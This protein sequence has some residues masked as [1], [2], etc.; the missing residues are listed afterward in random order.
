MLYPRFKK[1]NL[2][3]EKDKY[4]ILTHAYME[5][6]KMVPTTRP[7][8]Q[9]RRHRHKEQTLLDSVE[10]G[11]DGM[12]WENSTEAYTLSYVKQ[13]ASGSLMYDAGTQSQC[14]VTTWR[15]GVG[16][17]FGAGCRMERTNVCMRSIHTDEWQKPSKYGKVISLQLKINLKI[18]FYITI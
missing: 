14:S 18:S 16:K 3:L 9:Q 1:R 8:G 12:I 7:A 10:G 4:L 2:F 17:E 13:R 6:R 11:K 5:S 15:D